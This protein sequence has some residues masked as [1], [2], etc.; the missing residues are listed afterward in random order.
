MLLVA[1]VHIL[2]G[3]AVMFGVGVTCSC[4]RRTLVA[5]VRIRDAIEVREGEH[6]L[7]YQVS[8]R[9]SVFSVG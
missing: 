5:P 9:V 3:V 1:L 8:Y 7:R 2:G 6:L 4:G